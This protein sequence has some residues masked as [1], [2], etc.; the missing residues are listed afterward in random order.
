[1]SNAEEYKV[2]QV[3]ELRKSTPL[4]FTD[5]AAESEEYSLPFGLYVEPMEANGRDVTY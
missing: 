3:Q 5:Y 4:G 1:M 2:S